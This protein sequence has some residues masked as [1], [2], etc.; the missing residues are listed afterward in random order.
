MPLSESRKPARESTDPL[1][2]ILEVE[3][4]TGTALDAE[5]ARAARWLEQAR[6]ETEQAT[7]SEI[8]R[9][10]A[11]A[12]PDQAAAKQA[13][14]AKAGAIVEPAES[15]ARALK[16]LDEDRLKQI[17]WT[18]VATVVPRDQT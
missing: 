8:A 16:D 2:E 14:A 6:L 13:A 7:Q 17:V 3:K 1:D 5:R 10:K 12:A 9:L 18:H 4:A 11:S 15:F